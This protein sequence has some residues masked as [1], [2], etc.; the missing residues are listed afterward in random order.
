MRGWLTAHTRAP[1]GDP[2]HSNPYGFRPE[3][4]LSDRWHTLA[5]AKLAELDVLAKGIQRMRKALAIGLK[6]GC[7]RIEDCMLSPTDVAG[8]KKPRAKTSRG[9]AC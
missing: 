4:P 6:C 1:P 8:S 9:R 5:G 7:A 2:I 3:T